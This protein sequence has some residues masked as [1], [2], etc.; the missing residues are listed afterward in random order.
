MLRFGGAAFAADRGEGFDGHREKREAGD[1]RNQTET[2]PDKAVVEE[3]A[4]PVHQQCVFLDDGPVA[5]DAVHQKK[6]GGIEDAAPETFEAARG[7]EDGDADDVDHEDGDA[8]EIDDDNF[9][10]E[11]GDA[12]EERA[13]E[14]NLRDD[15]IEERL[16][17]PPDVAAG[18]ARVI[19]PWNGG[20]GHGAEDHA[21][22]GERDGD[23]GA[24]PAA[25]EVVEF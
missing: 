11:R 7:A 12:E 3:D 16:E 4:G 17:I 9:A 25:A 10:G 6:S 22:E 19:G 15:E 21:A 13:E 5:R 2:A 14:E 20:A 24:C 23:E 18:E 8:L 1:E